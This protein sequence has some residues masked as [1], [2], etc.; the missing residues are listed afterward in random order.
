MS[1][2]A[3]P[4]EHRIIIITIVPT[5]HPFIHP[6]VVIIHMEV[7]AAPVA[8][9]SALVKQPLLQAKWIRPCHQGPLLAKSDRPRPPIYTNSINNN[10]NNLPP[11]KQP[12]QHP[13][14]DPRRLT[15]RC[16][17]HLMSHHRHRP[18]RPLP[19]PPKPIHLH[20]CHRTI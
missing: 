9:K 3:A 8:T 19:T 15:T 14:C 7:P 4:V 13:L 16:D 17:H 18:H 11:Q 6:R 10:Q 5:I 12:Q 1:L 20:Q 2:T